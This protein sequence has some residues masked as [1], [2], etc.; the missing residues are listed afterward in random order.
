MEQ[1]VDLATRKSGSIAVAL[2]WDRS[3]KTLRVV[4]YDG[5]TD[6]EI[7]IPVSGDEASE[8]YQH[9]FAHTAR[10]IKTKL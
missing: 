8:V 10:S 2:V 3:D 6:E 7:V 5:L 1:V 9:P 4:A